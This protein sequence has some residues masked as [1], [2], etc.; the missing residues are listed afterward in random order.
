MTN[1]F[2]G[3]DDDVDIA[4]AKIEKKKE[5]ISIE[6]DPEK[7]KQLQDD[8]AKLQ[9]EL[10]KTEYETE[11]KRLLAGRESLIK[12]GYNTGQADRELALLEQKYPTQAK[13]AAARNTTI[14][15]PGENNATVTGA[16]A[17]NQMN[18]MIKL[19]TQQNQYLAQ[20]N[21]LLA[22]INNKESKIMI[23]ATEIGTGFN[24][25]SIKVA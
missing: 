20:Q 8:L 12:Q 23:G 15:T 11:K 7:K 4:E 3:L 14:R 25:N 10:S 19:Q 16:T 17:S 13:E 21:T 2:T 9:A 5:D 18:E 1:L 22:S 6:N 24:T